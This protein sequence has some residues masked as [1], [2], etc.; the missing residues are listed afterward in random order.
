MLSNKHLIHAHYRRVT[1]QFEWGRC[2]YENRESE[3]RWTVWELQLMQRPAVNHCKE[4]H[5][6]TMTKSCI[7]EEVHP[8][9]HI[10]S[11]FTDPHVIAILFDFLLWNTKAAKAKWEG[12]NVT[13]NTS[14]FCSILF[15]M[16]QVRY[17]V[18]QST[19]LQTDC[20]W[21]ELTSLSH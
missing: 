13:C 7:K 9:M 11:S 10:L 14:L 21:T 19:L 12:Q 6:L 8:I 4:I 3:R 5:A 18:T 1:R 17:K 16:V 15:Y 20:N 2:M